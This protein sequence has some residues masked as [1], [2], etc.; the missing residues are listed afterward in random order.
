M[1][2]PGNAYQDV[3]VPRQ[4]GLYLACETDTREPVMLLWWNPEA[5]WPY[6]FSEHTGAFHAGSMSLMNESL[7]DELFSR[8][9]FSPLTE[10]EAVEFAI[11]SA[12]SHLKW[13][14]DVI[15]EHRADTRAVP[16]ERVLPGLAAEARAAGD[17]AS[18]ETS[19]AGNSPGPSGSRGLSAGLTAS[20]GGLGHWVARAAAALMEALSGG[21]TQPG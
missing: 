10:A 2:L 16:A 19:G 6:V 17:R 3:I 20:I 4:G 13:S 9:A 11:N 5:F 1:T 18:N 7:G 15:A 21:R 12:H 8:F 14:Q